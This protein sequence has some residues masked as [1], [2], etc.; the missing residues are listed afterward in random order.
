M[1]EETTEETPAPLFYELFDGLPRQGP[2]DA[3]STRRALDMIPGV[4]PRTRLL[5]I[6][7]GTGLHTRVLARSAPL[8]IVAI[9]NHAPFVEELNRR[10]QALGF[11]D[12]LRAQVGDMRQLRFAPGSFDIVWSEGAIYLMGFEDGLRAWRPLLAPG[13]HVAVTEACWTRPDPPA[14]CADFWEQEYPGIRDVASTA[15][16]IPDCGYEGVGH[17]TLPSSSWWDDYY[18]P[19]QANVT[20]FRARH[21]DEAEATRLADQVQHEIDVWH[22]CSDYYGYEFFV[23]RAA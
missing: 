4:G 14:V 13:G 15:A 12:R 10:A 1:T 5:D 6:G 17:F 23:M 18:R 3:A 9:D 19:L 11:G 21:R 22:A 20:R 7:C 8:Q 16:A 2:G